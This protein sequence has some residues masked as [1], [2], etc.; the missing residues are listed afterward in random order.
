MV[1]SS[2]LDSGCSLSGVTSTSVELFLATLAFFATGAAA[3]L[4]VFFGRGT[5]LVVLAAVF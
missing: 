1:V 3:L 2:E 4:V 5:F